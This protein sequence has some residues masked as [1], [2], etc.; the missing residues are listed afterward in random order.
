MHEHDFEPLGSIGDQHSRCRTCGEVR[1]G[2]PARARFEAYKERR[3]ANPG[4]M[5][6][7]VHAKLRRDEEAANE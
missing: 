6:G 5:R 7:Y 4:V 1:N 2:W 3:L